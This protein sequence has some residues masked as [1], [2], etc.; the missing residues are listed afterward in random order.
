MPAWFTEDIQN[1]IKHRHY[2]KKQAN[3]GRVSRDTYNSARNK[4]VH[5]I[6]KVKSESIKRELDDNSR[7]P[8]NLCPVGKLR[9]TFD[10]LNDACRIEHF[11]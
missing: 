1:A 3:Q 7:N 11:N 10:N 9:S 8:K 5:T 2:L 6:E 4:V